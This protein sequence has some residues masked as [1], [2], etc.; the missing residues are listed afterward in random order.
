[1]AMK[2]EKLHSNS[3]ANGCVGGDYGEAGPIKRIRGG[4]GGGGAGTFYKFGGGGGYTGGSV[5]DV[6]EGGASF[7]CDPKGTM[8]IGSTGDGKI[9]VRRLA[10]D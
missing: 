2:N 3:F 10:Q 6:G 7:S 4:F 8:E 1:M 9:I 5:Y